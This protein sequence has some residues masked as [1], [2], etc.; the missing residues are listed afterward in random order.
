VVTAAVRPIYAILDKTAPEAT[1]YYRLRQVDLDGT[2]VHSPVVVVAGAGIAGK[3]LLYPNPTRGSIH[4][5]V[6]AATPY[7]VINQLGQTLLRGTIESGAATIAVNALAPGLY[8]LELQTA[9]GRVMQK[10]EKE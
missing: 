5:L 2:A 1:L 3:V 9:N 7:R 8:F 6:D 10:F 4:F